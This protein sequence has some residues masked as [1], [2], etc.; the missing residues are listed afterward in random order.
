M[1][2]SRCPFYNCSFI[3]SATRSPIIMA[4]P[5]V[6]VQTM[7]G[8]ME[9]STTRSPSSPWTQQYWSTTAVGS[10]AGPILQVPDMC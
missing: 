4:V 8:M 1:G 10:E 2:S 6:P 3:K 5:L 9:V 7:S